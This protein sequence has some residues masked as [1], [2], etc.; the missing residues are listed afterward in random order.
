[1]LADLYN[2]VKE[3]WD[4]SRVLNA[5]PDF[6]TTSNHNKGDFDTFLDTIIREGA[7]SVEKTTTIRDISWLREKG[8]CMDGI[9]SGRSSI[10]HAGRGAFATRNFKKGATI[11]PVPLIHIPNKDILTMYAPL[12]SEDDDGLSLNNKNK[13]RN[14]SQPIGKQLLVNYVFGHEKS[15][16][17]LS[18]YGSITSLINHGSGSDANARMVWATDWMPHPEWLEMTTNELLEHRYA[19]LGWNLVAL[20]DIRRDEEIRIDYG[21]GWEKAWKE[22]V[23]QWYSSNG[24][25]EEIRTGTSLSYIPASE[26]NEN[27]EQVLVDAVANHVDYSY[28]GRGVTLYCYY[29]EPLSLLYDD[30]DDE[31]YDRPEINVYQECRPVAMYR[32]KMGEAMFVAEVFDWEETDDSAWKLVVLD[33]LLAAH[34][35]IFHFEDI[36][37]ST[38]HRMSWAF[39]CEMAVPDDMLPKAWMNLP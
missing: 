28:M 26:L 15:T 27:I 8:V 37:F 14:I 34:Y 9:R 23:D 35:S 38:A 32:N 29:T 7:K 19:G 13:Q 12:F 17:L 6:T 1:M 36:P 30:N 21:P 16:M 20:R 39:R 3:A 22:H 18:P 11:A 24:R 10:P 33:T 31:H 5:L 25:Q 2:L 4:D